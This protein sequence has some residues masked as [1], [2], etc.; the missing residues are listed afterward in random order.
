ML[1][2]QTH[3]HPFQ[4][5]NAPSYPASIGEAGL[6]VM[7]SLDRALDQKPTRTSLLDRYRK[8]WTEADPDQILEATA[9]GYRFY[10]PIVGYFSQA[11]F[12][13]YFHLL[14]DR[15]SRTGAISRHDIGFFLRGPLDHR[16]DTERL[17]FWREA[18]RIGLTG[19]TVIEVGDRGIIAEKV[20]YDQNLAF[21][22]LGRTVQS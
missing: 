15:L 3:T 6:D 20:A 9:P 18:P 4:G 8:G 11:S 13:G 1:H 22:V 2:L 21:D 10:D 14:Q 12:H 7:Q 19:V 16:F 17:R 5:R